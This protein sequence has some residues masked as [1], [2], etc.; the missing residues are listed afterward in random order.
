MKPFYNL[1]DE[2]NNQLLLLPVYVS[3]QALNHGDNDNKTARE[4]AVRFAH[5]KTFSCDPLL[6]PFYREVDQ[7]FAG[8][9][10][11]VLEQLPED[12][13]ARK[14]VIEKKLQSIDKIVA[15]LNQPYTDV[16]HRSMESFGGHIVKARNSVL[17]KFA[18]PLPLPGL[19]I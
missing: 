7:N 13:A 14:E 11:S 9:L 3:L 15:K 18:L 1:T 12:P 2:E 5:T 17:S 16:I 19:D 4:A 8:S 10:E 6:I